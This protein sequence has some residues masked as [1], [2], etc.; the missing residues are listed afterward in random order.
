M[1][2]KDQFSNFENEPSEFVD[3]FEVDGSES[4]NNYLFKVSDVSGKDQVQL[5][6]LV[7]IK[8]PLTKTLVF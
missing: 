4:Y 2:Y 5:T 1:I 6:S 8:N 3:L 7:F